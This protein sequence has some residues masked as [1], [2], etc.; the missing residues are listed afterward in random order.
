[1]SY[2][3]LLDIIDNAELIDKYKI[4]V[5][6]LYGKA[7][8]SPEEIITTTMYSL[9]DFH[10]TPIKWDTKDQQEIFDKLIVTISSQDKNT[11]QQFP[12]SSLF[13]PN[14]KKVLESINTVNRRREEI[15]D[16]ITKE[17]L[18]PTGAT[19]AQSQDAIN[20]LASIE[21]I[22]KVVL[23]QAATASMHLTFG[24]GV[25][26]ETL[27][28]L[29]SQM[30]DWKVILNSASQLR[31][32]S[33]ES[34]KILFAEKHSP[35]ELTLGTTAD[36]VTLLSVAVPIVLRST[37]YVK[38]QRESFWMR[39][40]AEQE[41][42]GSQSGDSNAIGKDEDELEKLQSNA[43]DKGTDSL[44]QEL[45]ITKRGENLRVQARQVVAGVL[46]FTIK[47]GDVSLQIASDNNFNEKQEQIEEQ[48]RDVQ[49]QNRALIQRLALT[50]TKE[51]DEPT[52]PNVQVD[53]AISDSDFVISKEVIPP[54]SLLN[55]VNI[56]NASTEEL[57]ALP[58][59]GAKTAADIVDGRPYTAIEDLLK[60]SGVGTVKLQKLRNLITI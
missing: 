55:L 40:Q 44:L 27:E 36:I 3:K 38:L 56:N 59:I 60:I 19:L 28:D 14:A 53:D 24:G 39:R 8:Q 23:I 30:R 47:G 50:T 58:E 10:S 6:A 49:E 12:I 52:N 5:N 46:N 35:F 18:D 21:G 29:D 54:S 15:A 42:L 2:I 31:G 22:E 57:M 33:L 25:K 7:D 32:G 48:F 20:V 17:L 34:P 43:V 13:G 9:L 26:I 1:M 51:N 45:E 16:V 4:L 37:K 41:L 11:D